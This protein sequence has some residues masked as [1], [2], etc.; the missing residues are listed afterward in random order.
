MKKVYLTKGQNFQLLPAVV[1]VGESEDTKSLALNMGAI[2]DKVLSGLPVGHEIVV[3]KF[4]ASPGKVHPVIVEQG[5]GKYFYDED[6][7][8]GIPEKNVRSKHHR[9]RWYLGAGSVF[10]LN[11]GGIMKL[12]GTG[13]MRGASFDFDSAIE[14]AGSK[15][16]TKNIVDGKSLGIAIGSIV[17]VETG[18]DLDVYFERNTEK[19]YF[20]EPEPEQ[21]A[22]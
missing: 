21:E 12:G 19:F 9:G 6:I 10:T 5:S 11:G 14:A 7:T 2:Y 17:D 18:T 20:Y 4:E 16:D 3:G 8:V 15:P 13:S 22:E 1:T